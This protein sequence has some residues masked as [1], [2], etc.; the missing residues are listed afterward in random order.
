MNIFY[1]GFRQVRR[2][3]SEAKIIESTASEQSTRM[4]ACM[5]SKQTELIALRHVSHAQHD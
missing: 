1:T 4:Q 3:S 2:K 5:W